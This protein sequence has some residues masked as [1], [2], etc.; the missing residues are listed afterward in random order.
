[1]ILTL[2]LIYFANQWVH[3]AGPNYPI[4]LYGRIINEKGVGVAGAAI[5]FELSYFNEA[6]AP[7]PFPQNDKTK[8]V[9]VFTDSDG[10]FHVGPVYGVSIGPRRLFKAGKDLVADETKTQPDISVSMTDVES[11]RKMANTPAKR[12]TFVVKDPAP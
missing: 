5:D 6:P 3:D 12:M 8:I 9:T 4:D 7:T 10:N 11:R 2:L 1:M